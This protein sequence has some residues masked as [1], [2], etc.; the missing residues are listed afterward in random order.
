MEEEEGIGLANA[1]RIV[2]LNLNQI[3]KKLLQ[4]CTLS[5]SKSDTYS[6]TLADEVPA[7]THHNCS[8]KDSSPLNIHYRAEVL[9]SCEDNPCHAARIT[10]LDI[11]GDM[12]H[13]HRVT[14]QLL[15]ENSVIGDSKGTVV[16]VIVKT[17]PDEVLV[18][19]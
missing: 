5:C 17:A 18:C 11:G 13:I 9:R 16:T 6:D 12:N 15:H 14:L 3:T 4:T 10:D 1:E 19:P 8:Y 2:D 7:N